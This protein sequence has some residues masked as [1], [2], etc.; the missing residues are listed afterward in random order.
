MDTTIADYPEYLNIS[1]TDK[2][3]MKC[4]M[5]PHSCNDNIHFQ[6]LDIKPD[7]L[8]NIIFGAKNVALHG[9][10]HSKAPAE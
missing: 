6:E 1:I 4:V 3:P 10:K 2:C 7:K 8:H 5:C 9:G